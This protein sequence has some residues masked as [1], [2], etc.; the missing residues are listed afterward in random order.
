MGLLPLSAKKIAS[1]RFSDGEIGF[2]SQGSTLTVHGN[3]FILNYPQAHR[4]L[5]K[6]KDSKEKLKLKAKTAIQHSLEF[7]LPEGIDYGDYDLFLKLKTRYLKSKA[8]AHSSPL[9]L[10]PAAPVKPVL[11][12]LLVKDDSQILERLKTKNKFL[13]ELKTPLELG[14]NPVRSFYY[15]DGFKSIL[16]EPSYLFYLP[17]D[18]LESELILE[19]DR[20][21]VLTKEDAQLID[22]SDL[23]SYE[24]DGAFRTY[25]LDYKDGQKYLSKT[26]FESPIKFTKIHVKNPEAVY[27]YNHSSKEFPLAGCT[28]SDSTMTR[29]TSFEQRKIAAGSPF[30]VE[31]ALGLNDSGGD[32]L[33]LACPCDHQIFSSAASVIG[34][35]LPVCENGERDIFSASYSELDADGYAI[36]DN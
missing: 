27:L 12:P 15:E 31:A 13:L 11:E 26:I 32:K 1:P 2:Y 23:L 7:E 33:S 16:S 22:V 5:L 6:S 18:D 4:L 30:L 21:F 3:G 17:P 24:E 34:G 36:I 19:D 35:R 10:R 9:L 29:Y 28:L 8:V 25:F 20:A 14:A